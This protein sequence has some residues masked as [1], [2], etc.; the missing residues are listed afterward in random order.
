M[1]VARQSFIGQKNNVIPNQSMT[2]QEIVRRFIRKESLPIQKEGVYAEDLGDL[3]NMQR[4]DIVDRMEM[5]REFKRKGKIMEDAAK[6]DAA[7]VK[8]APDP[9][10]SGSV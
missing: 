9:S 1:K 6:E 8:D 10:E 5:A 7:K 4:E 3:E 2:L